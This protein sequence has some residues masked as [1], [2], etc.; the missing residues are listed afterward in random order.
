MPKAAPVTDEQ[1]RLAFRQVSR[2]G[3]P[4]TLEAALEHPLYRTCLHGIARNL[5]RAPLKALPRPAPPPPPE[6]PLFGQPEDT[7]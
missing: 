3:W 1:L 2:P 7:P 4:A 5:G 6:L